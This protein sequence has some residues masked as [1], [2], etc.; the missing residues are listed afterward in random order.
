[1]ATY[2]VIAKKYAKLTINENP[3]YNFNEGPGE[4]ISNNLYYKYIEEIKTA[5]N[6]HKI[7]IMFEKDQKQ[8]IYAEHEN[9]ESIYYNILE[10]E[11]NKLEK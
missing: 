7:I 1:M 6:I 5:T 2:K 4:Q 8:G 11:I 10:E 3:E 9:I